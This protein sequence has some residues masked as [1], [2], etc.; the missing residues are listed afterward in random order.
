[1]RLGLVARADNSGLGVQTLEFY[2]HMNPHKTM[3]V[4]ISNLNGNKVYPER[5]P[6]AIVVKGIPTRLDIDSFLDGLDVVF[7]AESP[8]NYYLYDRA[9]ELNVKVAVQYNYEFFDWFANPLYPK[10]DMLIAPSK[11]NYDVVD[12]WCRQNGVEH[13]YLHCPI[14]R[15]L[16][17]FKTI[18]KARTFL[19]TAGRSAAH[20]RNGTETVIKASKYLESNAKIVIHFQGEQGLGHQATHSIDYY[21]QLLKDH[22]D[23]NKVTIK[24]MDFKNYQD[25]YKEGDVLL[26]PR[27]YGGNCLPLNEALSVGMPAIM[28]AIS[29]NTDLLPEDWLVPASI[30][31]SFTPRTKIDI[32]ECDASALANKID[33]FYEKDE[34]EMTLENIKANMIAT[35]ISWEIMELGYER[36]LEKLSEKNNT[37]STARIGI[38][39]GDS[40]VLEITD[41]KTQKIKLERKNNDNDSST[42]I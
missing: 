28:S 32:Y 33:E 27:R 20:D 19:H 1:M 22:G 12:N 11:W 25:V 18:K 17:P 8:Y 16:L 38:N 7:V 5:Y 34:V 24:V 23:P 40:T 9:K 42:S 29:P 2:K 31:S 15:E 21:Q 4:D 35:Q 39:I 26:L 10:P 13:T 3:V 6:G 30:V 41:G 14:N 36:T 37:F